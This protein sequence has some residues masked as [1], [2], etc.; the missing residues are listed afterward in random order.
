[1]SDAKRW[2]HLGTGSLDQWHRVLRWHARLDRIRKALPEADPEKSLALDEVFAFFMNCFQ[3][4]DWLKNSGDKPRKEVDDFIERS[5]AMLLCRDICNGVKHFRLDPNRP[6]TTHP[7]LSSAASYS[8]EYITTE[9]G[10]RLVREGGHWV[11]VT[12][13]G[14]RD[15][16]ELADECLAAWRGYLKPWFG[17]K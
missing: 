7:N 6:T 4:A 3:M 12:D 1:M 5:P 14:E 13:D 15:M 11:F 9:T 16:F 10:P 17:I 8:R 2:S